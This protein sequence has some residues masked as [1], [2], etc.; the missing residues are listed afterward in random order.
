MMMILMMMKMPMMM[1]ISVKGFIINYQINPVLMLF[2]LGVRNYLKE[3]IMGMIEIQ[4]EVCNGIIN[5]FV[6]CNTYALYLSDI[7][8]CWL[9]L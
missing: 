9:N 3:A 5:L 4:A 6:T 8:F 1:T 7:M 2:I